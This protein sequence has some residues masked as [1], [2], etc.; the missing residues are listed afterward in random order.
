MYTLFGNATAVLYARTHIGGH[1]PAGS[2]L[3]LVT[4]H[5]QEDNRWFGAQMP[6]KTKSL[7]VVVVSISENG[8][9]SYAYDDYEGSPLEAVTTTGSRKDERIA[10]ILSQRAAVMP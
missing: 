4:W 3:S 2:M 10:C 7:E 6:A 8:P 9:L 1:Y 5:R